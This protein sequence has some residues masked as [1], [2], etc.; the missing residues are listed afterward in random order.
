MWVVVKEMCIQYYLKNNHYLKSQRDFTDDYSRIR[1]QKIDMTL[2]GKCLSPYNIRGFKDYKLDKYPQ[3]DDIDELTNL[4]KAKLNITKEVIIGNGANGLL[5][6]IIK[7]LFVN[8]GNLVTP[9]YTF[10]QAEYGVT[11]YGGY[12]KRVYCDNYKISFEKLKN[13]ID[14]KTRLVYICNPNNPTGIYVD[15]RQI[16][17]F[18]K[19]VKVPVI[20]DESGIEFSKQKSL[21]DLTEIPDNLIILRSFSKAYG[22]ADLRIGFLVCNQEIRKK[23][24]RGISNNEFSGISCNIATQIFNDYNLDENIMA[25]IEERSKLEKELNKL[26]IKMIKSDSNIIMTKTIFSDDFI[27]VLEENDMSVVPIYDENEN[28]HIRIAV[29]DEKTN[30]MFIEKLKNITLEKYFI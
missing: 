13:A 29:Q 22:I 11:S 9:F 23:Y 1:S 7:I 6:N 3:Q 24:L 21:L 16:L 28:L 20:I 4:L 25:I 30:L 14:H 19:Q 10:N 2:S 27:R 18:A 8:R 15:S 17:S 5:Q 26:N 12:T